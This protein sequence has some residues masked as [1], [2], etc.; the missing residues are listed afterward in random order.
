MSNPVLFQGNH[1]CH[2]RDHLG[3][4]LIFFKLGHALWYFS[5]MLSIKWIYVK[6]NH[7]SSTTIYLLLNSHI[8]FQLAKRLTIQCASPYDIHKSIIPN[9]SCSTSEYSLLW[10]F[11]S[12]AFSIIYF[13]GSFSRLLW[14]LGFFCG[15]MWTLGLFFSSTMLSRSGE[16]GPLFQILGGK[17]STFYHWIWC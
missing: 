10:I 11:W 12:I 14:L 4:P 16:C 13:L 8:H 6:Y 3:L 1:L 17:Y 9:K 15:S 5:P 2:S 7:S